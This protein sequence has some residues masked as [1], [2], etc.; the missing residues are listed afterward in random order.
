MIREM[1]NGDEI[2]RQLVVANNKSHMTGASC[3]HCSVGPKIVFQRRVKY[4]CN[5]CCR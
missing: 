5:K 1:F 3:S 4:E 2:L